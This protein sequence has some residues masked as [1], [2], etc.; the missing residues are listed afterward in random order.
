MRAQETKSAAG[1]TRQVSC[2]SVSDDP[3]TASSTA[4]SF[5]ADFSVVA[6]YM[7]QVL[8][9]SITIQ[10]SSL[11]RCGHT[12]HRRERV[13]HLL[14]LLPHKHVQVIAIGEFFMSKKHLPYDDPFGLKLTT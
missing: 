13:S 14:P 6:L 2:I 11:T 1:Q 12:P 4:G 8:A 10:K 7:K 5:T 9:H 3:F